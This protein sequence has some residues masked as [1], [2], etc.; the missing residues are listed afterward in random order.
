MISSVKLEN[1]FMT[2]YR[3]SIDNSERSPNANPY[4]II[5]QPMNKPH[6][7]GYIAL[8]HCW[9]EGYKMGESHKLDIERFILRLTDTF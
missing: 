2:G 6:S 9:E 1:A 7:P 5:K 8:N 3:Y 4:Y